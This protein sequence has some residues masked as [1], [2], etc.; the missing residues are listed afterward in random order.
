MG[1]GI[2]GSGLGVW[3]LGSGLGISD[4]SCGLQDSYL[5]FWASGFG[6]SGVARVDRE[7]FIDNPLVRIHFI[8]EMIWWTG[9][10]PREF[11]F[12]FLDSLI[13]TFLACQE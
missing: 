10:A 2:L 1:F 12:P 9:L 4:L 8:I 13:S 5:W 7:S 6:F 3:V 11:E